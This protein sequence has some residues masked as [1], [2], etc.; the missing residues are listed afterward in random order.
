[1]EWKKLADF[2]KETIAEARKQLHQAVQLPAIA[3]RC[4][5]LK[6]PGDT[7][8]A[9]SWD[10]NNNRLT[11]QSL[12]ESEFHIALDISGF[13]LVIITENMEPV[14][15]FYLDSKTYNEAFNWLRENLNQLSFGSNKLN[16]NLPYQIPEYPTAKGEPFRQN[17]YPAFKE[18]ENY[19]SNANLI[20]EN[21]TKKEKEVSQIH[22]WPHHFDI[23]ALI[24]IEKNAEQEKSKT[25]GLGL[26]PGD[27]SYN[28]PYFYISPWPYPENKDNLPKLNYGHWHTQGW[29]GVVLTANEIVRPVSKSP[30]KK[31]VENFIDFGIGN[32]K[33]LL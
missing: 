33:K 12:G 21:I 8:A 17:N 13:Q 19:Y 10:K 27:E 2:S 30:Q 20:L 29:F 6:D 31:I 23:A 1:M 9:L 3:G 32:L 5:N 14:I 25:I 26:S 22:C 7:F 4:L 28:E 16:K 11:S 24:T 18:L 15:S